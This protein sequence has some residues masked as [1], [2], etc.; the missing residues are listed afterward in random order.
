MQYRSLGQ[1]G[2]RVS[3]LGLGTMGITMAYGP[4]DE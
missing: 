1:E 2:L 3:A 4:A